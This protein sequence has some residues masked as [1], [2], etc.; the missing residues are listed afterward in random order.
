MSRK[1]KKE[2]N[3]LELIPIRKKDQEWIEKNGLVEII[4]PRN[5]I[6]ERIIRPIFKTPKTMKIELDALGS[7]VWKSIDGER[8]VM[9]IGE[10]V[11]EEFG[12]D[13]EPVYERLS[14]YINILRNNKFVILEKK[15]NLD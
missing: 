9:D 14:T 5:A 12:E 7:C 8:A 3:F 11:K 13:A 2:D 10:I 6:L 15:D 1:F 4:V